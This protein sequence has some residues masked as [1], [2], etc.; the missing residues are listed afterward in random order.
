LVFLPLSFAPLH[1]LFRD[2]KRLA[3]G[4]VEA[5]GFGLA[6]DWRGWSRFHGAIIAQSHRRNT[7]VNETA[8]RDTLLSIVTDAR[9]KYIMLSST[10]NKLAALRETV[11]GLDPTFRDVMEQKR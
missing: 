5:L 4:V 10:L 6:G 2:G 3:N 11:R 8:L 7:L 9:T 1:L